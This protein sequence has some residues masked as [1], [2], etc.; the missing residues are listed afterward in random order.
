LVTS[1]LPASIRERSERCG[2]PPHSM[3]VAF[4][5]LFIDQTCAADLWI[6]ARREHLAGTMAVVSRLRI[7]QLLLCRATES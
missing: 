4:Q 7:T 3:Q 1:F 6:N 5:T 2:V